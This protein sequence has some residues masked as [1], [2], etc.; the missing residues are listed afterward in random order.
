MHRPTPILAS[1]A[2]GLLLSTHTTPAAPVAGSWAHAGAGSP[3]S[4]VA[5][6]RLGGWFATS[7]TATD[8]VEIRDVRQ[9]LMA[10]LTRDDLLAHAPWMSLDASADGPRTLAW[11]DSGRSLFIV[12]T[13]EAPSSDGL[14]SDMVLRYDT[15]TGALSRFARANIG[16]A[17]GPALGAAHHQGEL[18]IAT[19]AGPVRV[20][21]A[22]RSDTQGVLSRTWSLPDAAPV[23]SLAVSQPLG[24]MLAASGS[25]L[26]RLDLGQSAAIPELVGELAGIRAVTYSAHYGAIWQEGAYI[27]TD[28]GVLHAPRFEITGL[29]PFT[30]EPYDTP[31]NIAA[32]L[33]ATP[34]GR[35]MLGGAA[36]AAMVRDDQDTRL[37]YE[38]WLRDELEQ[39]MT[40]ARGLVSPDGEPA[41]WVID[42]DVSPGASRFHPASP[43]GAAWVVMLMIAHDQLGG[44]QAHAGLVR[45]VLTRYAGLAGDGVAPR[46]TANGIMHHWYDPSTGLSA[47]GWSDEYATMST[48]LLVAA[49]DRAR[50]FYGSD[51]QIVEAADVIVG[52]VNNWESYLQPLSHDLYLRARASGGPD[53]NTASA[54]FH[55]GVLFVDQAAVFGEGEPALGYWL[56]RDR[57][58]SAQY[59]TGLPVSSNRP[60]G[61]LPA[62]VSLYPLIAQYSFRSRPE[63]RQHAA[64]LLASNG[65]WTDDNAP[66]QMTVFSAGTTRADWGGYHADSLSDH[67]G[68]V[69]TFPALMGFGALG[70]TASSVGAYRAYRTGARQAFATGASL[71]F[72]R[73]Q[74]D[75]GFAPGDAGLSDVVVGALGLAE[76]IGPG[77]IDA[78]LAVPYQR[79][80]PADFAEPLGQLNFFDVSAFLSAY[81]SDDP[82]ADLA[83]PFGSLDFFDVSA[84]LSAFG[85]GCP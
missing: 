80:C 68:D 64:N 74:I 58:P 41:G 10:R 22:Q 67:P 81:L 59:V 15:T 8:T 60:G 14:G 38:D 73:S 30:P 82:A 20:Y 75:P 65:A 27:A 63:W 36:G 28:S 47:P 71:L 25:A 29:L 6:A 24:L 1:A 35:L 55:E 70:Q 77:T 19:D 49:A 12:V 45:S 85:A 46:V 54:G 51:A 5:S 23:V 16:D 57:L 79:D 69:T 9:T 26:H 17:S 31:S 3:V 43:D 7:D 21:L 61:H 62:F 50:R 33:A 66:S 13:D 18:W 40:F 78:V 2:I 32:S 56:D 83:R 48:M 72:R 44:A 53:F 39:V 34:C 4:A 11:T 37:G 84:Y 42:A 76:L 52:R